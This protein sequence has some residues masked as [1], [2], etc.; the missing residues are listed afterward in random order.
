MILRSPFHSS[1]VHEVTS[2]VT[3]LKF[4]KIVDHNNRLLF[5]ICYD[6]SSVFGLFKT[7]RSSFSLMFLFSSSLKFMETLKF[8]RRVGS[9]SL[10]E[11]ISLLEILC[12]DMTGFYFNAD[13]AWNP[14]FIALV[15][16]LNV[17]PSLEG[18]RTVRVSQA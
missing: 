18:I 15:A 11:H 4:S 2:R 6:H 12:S 1:R 13:V 17:K 8:S 7:S 10:Q 3:A 16:P 14:A 5:F 9:K